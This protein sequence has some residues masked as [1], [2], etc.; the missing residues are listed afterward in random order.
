MQGSA[1]LHERMLIRQLGA[2]VHALFKIRA[3]GCE[4]AADGEVAPPGSAS[5]RHADIQLR[6]EILREE[7]PAQF[8]EALLKPLV[9]PMLHNIEEAV[10]AASLS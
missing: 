10:I 7:F 8:L 3:A 1:R 5:S 9:D 4:F 6:L 2:E